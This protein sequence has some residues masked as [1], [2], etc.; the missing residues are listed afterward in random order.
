MT[1]TRTQL[2]MGLDGG[3]AE[4]SDCGRYR[5]RL[6]RHVGR[7]DDRCA[8]VMLN[9]STADQ[10]T[11]DP[12]LLRCIAF[13]KS[14]GFGWLEVLNV[15]AWRSTDPKFL[16]D[17]DDPI[18]PLTDIRIRE[19]TQDVS[20][21]VCAWGAHPLAVPRGRVVRELLPDRELH[22]LKLTRDGDP[23]HPLYQPRNLRPFKFEPRHPEPTEVSF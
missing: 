7:G 19:A 16:W 3:G 5:Y 21:I 8:F 13:A 10:N 20:L 4:F 6:W 2:V 1:T 17:V 12:T 11:N 18:G 15:F 9:P 23:C 14:W 22:A